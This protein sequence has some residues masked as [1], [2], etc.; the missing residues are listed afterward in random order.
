MLVMPASDLDDAVLP[1]G[2][3][4]E[5]L[6]AA[7]S[8]DCVLVPGSLEDVVA[9]GSDVRSHAGVPRHESLRIC[10]GDWTPPRRRA[11]A[12]SLSQASRVP[13]AFSRRFAN[14]DSSSSASCAFRITTGFRQ[15]TSIAFARSRNDA[16]ADLVVTTEKDAVR[17][18]PQS[19]WA[20]LPMTAV[21]E[22]ART[23]LLVAP[24]TAV[25][26]RLEF[27]VRAIGTG[28]PA[29]PA[30]DGRACVWG[31]T[32]RD[33]V[34]R[35]SLSSPH[36]AWTIWR[37]HF[38]RGPSGENALVCSGMFRH[39]GSLLLEL[40]QFSALRP[41]QMLERVEVEGQE[42]VRQAYRQGKG[43]LYFTGHFGYWE[44][45]AI[46]FAV[47]A[48][49]I[50]VVARPLD[51]PHLHAMLE[52]IRT[53]TGNA[54]IYRQGGLRRVLRD[55]QSNRGVAMLIDQHL[56]SDAV[57]VEFFNRPAATTSALGGA[58]ACEPARP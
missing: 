24:G 17:V 28:V 38:H 37:R 52:R 36:R 9:R 7:S 35:R 14:R 33:G 42:H 21:I 49:P 47:H 46:A 31:R 45:Q 12:S 2:R 25:R 23:V 41:E 32:R 57:S 8:A 55:L 48:E 50:S 22:P 15:T 51:N 53:C 13:S 1:S 29:L 27:A 58:G 4:R 19:G 43:V 26:H 5:P 20:V 39:F 34:R 3:L 54:V 56:H 6:D 10:P 18:A 16:S 11:R 44:I 30:D 40:I